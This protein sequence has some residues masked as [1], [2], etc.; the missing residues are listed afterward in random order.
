[1]G[2]LGRSSWTR[3]SFVGWLERGEVKNATTNNG[4]VK[5]VSGGGEA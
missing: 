3:G 1:M 4:L 5:K 2:C